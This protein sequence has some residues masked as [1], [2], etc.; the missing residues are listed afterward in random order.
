MPDIR[1]FRAPRKPIADPMLDL[2]ILSRA[3][4]FIGNCVSSFTAFVKRSR[5]VEE[6][7]PSEFWGR[8]VEEL[9]S[10]FWVFKQNHKGK[11]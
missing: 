11:F 1:V 2:C 6:L 10:E 7:L 3:D 5:D 8:D 9:P 4:L